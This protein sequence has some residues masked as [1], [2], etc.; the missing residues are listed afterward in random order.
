MAIEIEVVDGIPYDTDFCM[1]NREM[2]IVLRDAALKAGNF[3]FA[4]GLS[5]TIAIMANYI[6]LLEG[7]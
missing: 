1:R 5:H 3:E 4:V 7:R 2:L 6:K